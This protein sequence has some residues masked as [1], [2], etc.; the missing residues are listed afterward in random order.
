MRI[1]R[2]QDKNWKNGRLV[3]ISAVTAFT[4]HGLIHAEKICRSFGSVQEF[5]TRGEDADGSRVGLEHRW[6]SIHRLFALS[7]LAALAASSRLV[8]QSHSFISQGRQCN[9]LCMDGRE[10]TR[11]CL[12]VL[13][14]FCT[15]KRA[16]QSHRI[17]GQPLWN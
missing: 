2:D 14:A 12:T 11:T 15:A 17:Y 1:R 5:A 16:G 3:P 8:L 6:Y 10:V 9:S 7:L 4:R 13:A